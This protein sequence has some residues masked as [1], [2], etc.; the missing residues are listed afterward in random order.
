MMQT[1]TLILT[2]AVVAYQASAACVT[3]YTLP[4]IK[5]TSFASGKYT[6]TGI[7]NGTDV[8]T[9]NNLMYYSLTSAKAATATPDGRLTGI[10]SL[11]TNTGT[12]AVEF[13]KTGSWITTYFGK[14]TQA[15]ANLVTG[16]TGCFAGF[17]GTATRTVAQPKPV[18]FKW[19][20]CPQAAKTC[21]AGSA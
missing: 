17:T 15:A 20:F 12:L 4:P 18:I 19:D 10:L 6:Y 7:K 5:T 21:A 11:G 8:Q 2:L 9:Y 16:G 1:L 14:G 3:V 13:F